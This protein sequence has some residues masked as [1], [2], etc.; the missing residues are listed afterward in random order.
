MVSPTPTSLSSGRVGPV[1]VASYD[2]HGRSVGLFYAQP[3]GQLNEV[4]RTE[5]AGSEHVVDP[6]VRS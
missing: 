3:T 6:M 4:L 1:L 5:K 2:M